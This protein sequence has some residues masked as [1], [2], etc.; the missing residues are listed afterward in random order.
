MRAI[1]T[2]SNEG[3]G[4]DDNRSTTMTSCNISRQN[5]CIHPVHSSEKSIACPVRSLLLEADERKVK[6]KDLNS[7]QVFPPLKLARCFQCMITL[8]IVIQ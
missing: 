3:Y 1:H 6:Q 7:S 4:A 8:S 2:V 5:K